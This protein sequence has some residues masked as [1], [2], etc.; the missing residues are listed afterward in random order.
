MNLPEPEHLILKALATGTEYDGG[1]SSCF[2]F[3]HIAA[4]SGVPRPKVR[5]AVR[6]L[7]RRGLAEY[8]KGLWSEDG[9]PAGAGYGITVEGRKWLETA[10]AG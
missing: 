5:R 7:A 8:A 6:S 3:N 1:A 4:I 10:E 2:S 9:Q